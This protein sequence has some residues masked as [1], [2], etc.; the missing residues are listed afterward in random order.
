MEKLDNVMDDINENHAQMNQINDAFAN[1]IGDAV[2]EDDLMDEL[3]ELE[4]RVCVCCVVCVF[5]CRLFVC[6]S[7]GLSICLSVSVC[8][9]RLPVFETRSQS[10]VKGL[11]ERTSHS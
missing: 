2:D 10:E 11:D 1:P 3:N 5:V 4:V 8:L 9:P 7:I 6:L